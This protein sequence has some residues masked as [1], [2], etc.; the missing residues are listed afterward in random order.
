M[1]YHSVVRLQCEHRLV[2]TGTPIENSLKDLWAQFNF[3]NP[4]L[5]WVLRT[6]S[7]NIFIHPITKEGNDN[8]R[9]RLQQIIRPFFSEGAPSNRW[10]PLNFPVDGRGEVIL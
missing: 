3:I 6:D 9:K 2:L 5:V 4:G 8:A 1:T 10:L 7:G